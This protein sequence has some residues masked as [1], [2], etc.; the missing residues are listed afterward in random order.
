MKTMRRNWRAVILSLS[1]CAIVRQALPDRLPVGAGAGSELSTRV[2]SAPYPRVDGGENILLISVDTL[3]A[4]RLSCYGYRR[5][6]TPAIDRWAAEGVRF[7]RAYT[8]YPLTLPAH[9]TL[10]T[11]T[12]PLYHGVRENV[13][14]S[15]AAG[16]VTLAEILKR[17]GFSTAAFIGCYVLASQFGM[18]QGFDT[19]DEDFGIPLEKVNAAT[20]LRRPAEQVTNHF[21]AWLDKH[22]TSRFFAFVHFYDPHAPCPNGYDREVSRVD[23]GIARIDAFLRGSNLLEKTYIFYLSDH[24][25]SLGEH[26]ESGHGFFLYDS[27]LRV[28]LIVRPAASSP[29]APRVVKQAASLADVMPTVLQ[30]AGLQAPAHLQGRS[31]LPT[32]LGK[33]TADAGQYAETYIPQLHFGWSPLRSYRLGHYVF[34]DAPRAELYDTT[35]DPGQSTNLASQNRA[36]ASQYRAR[37]QEFAARHQ[38]RPGASAS[39]GPVLEAR[40]KLA[41]LGYVQLSAPKLTG[42]FGKGLDPKDRIQAFESYH[43]ILN[44]IGSRNIQPRIV[45]RLAALRKMAPE[46]RSLDFLEA[47]ASEALGRIPEAQGKYLQGLEIEPENSVARAD[48]AHLLL[49]MGRMDE[50]E[51]QF[52]RVVADDP[53]DYRSRSN[54]AGIYAAKGKPD[55][56]M[57]ELKLALST[58]PNYAVGWHNLG[59]LYV[60]LQRWKEAEIAMRKAV[61]LDD[62]SA[63]AHFLLA[64][65]LGTVGK[66]SEAADHLKIAL[67]LNPGLAHQ[68][69]GKSQ[70]RP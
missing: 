2:E 34:I 53:G 3:R 14:F 23:L 9:S 11:G 35:A 33:E 50:A 40:E 38:A 24:G 7:E 27:T 69:P 16:Q 62:K 49:R 56:A 54:L 39:A 61:A 6:K 68:I 65:V 8:E 67:K 59:Q 18:G 4:D 46:V 30:M 13:G 21:L 29:L 45:E 44:E 26:G 1:L 64:Q 41:S 70:E 42:D 10:L 5:N 20:A 17:N 32:M 58:R 47:Q 31:L 51:Q 55:A 66:K 60:R 48:Y 37:L 52:Q 28:P 43:D 57:A 25:E 15:L 36:L 22:R 63:A 19:Y 12:Y